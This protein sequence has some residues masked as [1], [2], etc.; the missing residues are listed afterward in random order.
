MY[1]LDHRWR[2]AANHQVALLMRKAKPAKRR[3]DLSEMGL[4]H[5]FLKFD[6]WQMLTISYSHS[7]HTNHFGVYPAHVALDSGMKLKLPVT[8]SRKLVVGSMYL[9]Y[10]MVKQLA[11]RHS[12]KC[13]IF[14]QTQSMKLGELCCDQTR[15][16][17]RWWFG[18]IS[19]DLGFEND[20]NLPG[21]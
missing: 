17:Y 11:Q 10:K 14:G 13:T 4:F 7:F 3:M 6:G 5:D 2:W 9:I 15:P 20:G 12:C 21:W 16:R 18:L 1:L 19:A 8:Q